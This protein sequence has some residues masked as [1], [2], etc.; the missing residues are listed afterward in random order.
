MYLMWVVWGA[1]YFLVFPRCSKIATMAEPVPN[2]ISQS[3]RQKPL[4]PDSTP[5]QL[6]MQIL[7]DGSRRLLPR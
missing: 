1:S 4:R 2:N 6:H 7:Q 5:L 3:F